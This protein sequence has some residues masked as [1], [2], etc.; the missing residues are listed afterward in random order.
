MTILI[1]MSY[2]HSATQYIVGE[3][4]INREIML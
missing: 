4:I 1:S 3:C 2:N